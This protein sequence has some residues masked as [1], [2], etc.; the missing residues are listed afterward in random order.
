[1]ARSNS[2]KI[3]FEA[4]SSNINLKD[5]LI[6]TALPFWERRGVDTFC[7]GFFESL[8][9][10]QIPLHGPRRARLVARQIF[11]FSTGLR[12]GWDGP[13]ISLVQHG[14]DF[15][16]A[17]Y[18]LEDGKVLSAIELSSEVGAFGHDL[19]DYAFVL[20]G[21][22]SAY[23]IMGNPPAILAIAKRI[24]SHLAEFYAHPLGGYWG[25]LVHSSPL[26]ANPH[27]H[28]LEAF[29]AWHE[30]SV[31]LDSYWEN[32]AG[33]IVMLALNQLIQP[34]IGCLPEYFD[35][36]WQVITDQQGLLIEPGHQFEWAWLLARWSDLR[37]DERVFLASLRLAQFGENYGVDKIRN[38][39]IKESSQTGQVRD[40]T[41]KLWP[42]TERVKAWHSLSCHPLG[43]SHVQLASRKEA[44]LAVDSLV[45]FIS[46]IIPG[47][48]YESM[49]LDETFVH[50]PILA[51]SFYHLV[52]AIAVLESSS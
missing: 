52:G 33:D 49:R 37:H 19:Y 35:L 28:L 32:L 11:C 9:E 29:L 6:G 7:G 45:R 25:D 13:A 27:M 2:G 20:F 24:A 3:D 40:A 23:Q 22:S 5:W 47:T 16:K 43:S 44:R 41:A 12:L 8:D 39:V 31:P 51:S 48:W 26:K 18:I 34:D 10:H 50:F 21:L 38:V 17:N 4:I 36:K 30:A 14:L 1:M 46:P 15:L 42:Q